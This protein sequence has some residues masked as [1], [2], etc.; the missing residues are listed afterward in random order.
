MSF[1]MQQIQI[2][3]PATQPEFFEGV[4][5]KRLI[6]WTLDLIA[7]TI[8][9]AIFAT[10]P[11]FIGW[12]FFPLVFL[13]VKL[14]YC[15]GTISRTSATPGMRLMN[16]EL[17]NREGRALEPSE[18]AVYTISY[19]IS[20][21]FVIPQLITLALTVITPKGQGL[22][23]MFAGATVINSPSRY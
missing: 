3:D 19:V 7:I 11:L 1:T 22:H 2:P 4:I 23:D 12:F 14:V 15:I 17:R 18:A 20:M 6:A 10:L 16:I 9:A 21:A 8:I 13:A 5:V